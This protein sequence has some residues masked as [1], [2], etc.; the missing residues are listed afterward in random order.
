MVKGMLEISLESD[1]REFIAA[2][3]LF[4]LLQLFS[5]F[6]NIVMDNFPI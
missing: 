6:R 2:Y 3:E 5:S 4:D 1:L